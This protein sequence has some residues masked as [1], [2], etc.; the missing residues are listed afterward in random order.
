[1]TDPINPAATEAWAALSHHRSAFH[2]S[3]RDLFHD[4]P[5]RADHMTYQVADLTVDLSKH[6]A[7][8]DT[9]SLLVDLANST[10]VVQ[11]FEAMCRGDRINSTEDR[12]VLH[13]ALR[14]QR[15]DSLEVDGVDVV[16]Q[17]H[18]VL[19]AMAALAQRV[20]TGQWLG[21]DGRPIDA[22]VNIGIGGSDLGPAMALRA[23]EPHVIDGLSF[24]FVSNVDPVQM[25]QTLA[26]LD[27]ATTLFLV[28]SKTFTMMRSARAWAWCIRTRNSWTT[29]RWRKTSPCR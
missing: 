2:A 28:A 19:G 8:S 16:A 15:S 5:Q 11:R 4:D 27:P 6:L 25:S 23:L 21:F 1:M 10:G 7:T 17:V 3:L 20:R 24:A 12:A 13:T 22:V 14:R 9:V 29:C 26:R 18:D